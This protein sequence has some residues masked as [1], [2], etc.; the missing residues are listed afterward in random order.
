M[1]ERT[2]KKELKEELKKEFNTNNI[3]QFLAIIIAVLIIA[4]VFL[5]FAIV[6]KNSSE[7]KN[8]SDIPDREWLSDNCECVEWNGARSC[9]E[10]F[11][12]KNN[13]CINIT[14]NVKTNVLIACS[15]Y[16]CPEYLVN[17]TGD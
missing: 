13:V 7:A 6:S 17:V 2:A 3:N 5:A 16:K 14:R 15:Q 1:A 11:E 8:S 9:I 12:L 10:G 4:V